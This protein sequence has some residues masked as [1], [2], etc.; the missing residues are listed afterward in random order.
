MSISLTGSVSTLMAEVVGQ[1]LESEDVDPRTAAW[2]Q[3]GVALATGLAVAKSGTAKAVAIL[4]AGHYA[5]QAMGA[6]DIV[7]QAIDRLP[8]TVVR[9]ALTLR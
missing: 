5:A 8:A 6:P 2:W 1:W 3:A 7:E 4:M 9:S